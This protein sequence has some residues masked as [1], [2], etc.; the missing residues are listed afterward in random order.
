MNKKKL[1]PM[2]KSP[3]YREFVTQR[4]FALEIIHARYQYQITDILGGA[5]QRTM[6][7]VSYWYDHSRSSQQ[8]LKGI[9]QDVA[10][11]FHQSGQEMFGVIQ[12]FRR[13]TYILANAGEAEAMARTIGKKSQVN[14][15]K[16]RL[17]EIALKPMPS[18]GTI[19]ER[20][21]LYLGRLKRKILDAVHLA[22]TLDEERA[23]ALERVIRTFPTI[24]R[25]KK[26]TNELKEVKMTESEK[27]D[28]IARVLGYINPPPGAESTK[29]EPITLT[30]GFID[31]DE[32]EDMLDAYKSEYIPKWRGPESDL[33]VMKGEGRPQYAWELEKD[34]TQ[35]F[36]QQVRD[37]QVDSANENG[38]DEFQWI[39]VIDSKTD[40]CCVWRD[41]LTTSEIELELEQE[42]SDDE[43]EA[44]VPPAHFNCRCTLAPMTTDMPEA[45]P[46]RIGEFSEWL[47]Q[48]TL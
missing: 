30:N 18:G 21:D 11:A 10:A 5:L 35:D 3:R 37:G 12:R 26:P 19:H 8:L 28:N 25:Y 1:A 7:I 34:M 22:A 14:L 23:E 42:H 17:A 9:D 48:T 2:S 46:Q 27:S 4:D 24:R 32:W 20:V 40:D 29:M 38:I 6:E 13:N 43:C 36:V 41:G 33:E 39:S 15:T 31:P 45:P 47:E 16:A 44:T